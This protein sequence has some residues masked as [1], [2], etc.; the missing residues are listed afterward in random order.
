MRASTASWEDG[1]FRG[2]VAETQ[3]AWQNTTDKAYV[4][5]AHHRQY[6]ARRPRP[7][8]PMLA[9]VLSASII[10]RA[11]EARKKS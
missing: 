8:T 10:S 1:P 6:G 9:T 3:L 11:L 4:Q 5:I 7:R 2:D